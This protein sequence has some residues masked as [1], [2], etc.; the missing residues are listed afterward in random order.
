[1]GENKK[2]IGKAEFFFSLWLF[3]SHQRVCHPVYQ[4]SVAQVPTNAKVT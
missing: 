2:T 4:V 3:Q 1:M